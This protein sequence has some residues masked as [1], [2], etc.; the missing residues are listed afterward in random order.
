MA[1]INEQRDHRDPQPPPL[2]E[3]RPRLM[4]RFS[5]SIAQRLL[6]AI[7]V[8]V[9]WVAIDSSAA[10][11]S[12]SLE[13]IDAL[14]QRGRLVEA[15]ALY[16]A[17]AP[18]TEA[19]RLGQLQ[20]YCEQGR[21]D[22]ALQVIETQL[23]S[24]DPPPRDW[25]LWKVDV[26]LH[27]ANSAAAESALAEAFPATDA[28]PA[29]SIPADLE[30]PHAWWLVAL[31]RNAQYRDSEADD[32]LEY[33]SSLRKLRRDWTLQDRLWI[34]WGSSLHGWQQGDVALLSELQRTWWPETLR[35]F[36]LAWQAH[37]AM[38][39][40]SLLQ[41]QSAS[42]M[43]AVDRGL[44]IH[45]LA[46]PL[47]VVKGLV[48]FDDFEPALAEQSAIRALQSCKDDPLANELL[49]DTW[50][51]TGQT[52]RAC[53][54]LLHWMDAQPQSPQW[55]G[56][57]G[58][59]L[60][61]RAIDQSL[62]PTWQAA[63]DKIARRSRHD[64]IR[65]ATQ[66]HALHA[67][68]RLP[69]AIALL[70]EAAEHPSPPPGVETDLG[71]ILV[72]L[73]REDEARQWLDR[74]LKRD[75]SNLR[76]R[77][78]QEVLRTLDSYQTIQADG[79]RIRFDPM[80][81]Q[82]WAELVLEEVRTQTWPKITK[83]M[84]HTPPDGVLI[85]IFHRKD[86]VSGHAWFSARMTALPFVDTVAACTGSVVACVAPEAVETPVHWGD[87]LRHEL[88]HVVNLSQTDH[89]VPHWLTEG[90]AVYAENRPRPVTWRQLLTKRITSGQAFTPDT[91][92]AGFIR[93]R[94]PDD[95]MA[96]Y[97][98]AEW[99]VR[100]AIERFGEDAPAKM[101]QACAD[102]GSARRPI[103]ALG[104]DAEVFHQDFIRHAFATFAK[105]NLALP[106]RDAT[107]AAA[108]LSTLHSTHENDPDWHSALIQAQRDAGLDQ[109]KASLQEALRL[110]PQHTSL[111]AH[112]AFRM[113]QE[114]QRDEAWAAL[115]SLVQAETTSDLA[116]RLHCDLAKERGDRQTWQRAVTHAADRSSDPV[117]FLKQV[118]AWQLA[119]GSD[120]LVSTLEKLADQ[121]PEQSVYTK[122]LAQLA[123]DRNDSQAAKHWGRETVFRSPT[124][125]SAWEFLGVNSSR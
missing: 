50:M 53:E 44:A 93:P 83:L 112:D 15:L 56:R 20:I 18:A 1:T 37:A 69:A 81:G 96:A 40:Q 21:W 66:A 67:M 26:Q 117:P 85:E 98:Q 95:R 41:H 31:L 111:R 71:L 2:A 72:H 33:L 90:L 124:D 102:G 19:T 94:Q 48:A 100:Y 91:I 62:R 122:K 13:E 8:I 59:L 11:A 89:G 36:P 24:S 86:G 104:I 28:V 49:I 125:P 29:G 27:Q 82:R 42:A 9:S 106:P 34:G 103:E 114:N 107:L 6:I 47:H 73:A 7:F 32:A 58:A 88:V 65:L 5:F 35:R 119:A 123:A 25:L 121:L 23:G 60:E 54:A 118:A 16:D 110:A 10:I 105:W 79:I 61:V 74:G 80:L 14:R 109:W 75:P 120:D 87:T 38:G 63:I 39:H 64:G 68:R 45:P 51:L 3:H 78:M 22:Q 92:N 57:I 76:G 99:Y 84:G 116:L 77:N 12:E 97:A 108:H 52:D 30:E 113:I 43:E 70:E 46:A 55:L 17:I 115:Q 101:L 4:V